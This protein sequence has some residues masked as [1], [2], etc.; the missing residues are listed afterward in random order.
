MT[1]LVVIWISKEWTAR[2]QQE[3]G[4]EI[5]QKKVKSDARDSRSEDG[6]EERK[7]RIEEGSC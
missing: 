1:V 6:F 2:I 3:S 7:L 4:A 5:G